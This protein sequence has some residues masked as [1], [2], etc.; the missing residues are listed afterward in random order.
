MDRPD[1]GGLDVEAVVVKNGWP[2]DE[3][4]FDGAKAVV[5][6]ADG[7]PKHPFIGHLDKVECLQILGDLEMQSTLWMSAKVK[8]AARQAVSQIFGLH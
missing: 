6:Y 3:T 4:V 7:G 2:K 8:A 5:C 1:L